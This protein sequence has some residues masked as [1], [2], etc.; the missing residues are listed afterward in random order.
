MVS[1]AQDLS[2]KLFRSVQQT[3]KCLVC[4]RRRSRFSRDPNCIGLSL[5]FHGVHSLVGERRGAE[6]N[7]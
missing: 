3:P 2:Q 5:C 1:K 7:S 4:A 6:K